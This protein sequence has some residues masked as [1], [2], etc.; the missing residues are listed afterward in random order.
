MIRVSLKGLAA[1]PIRAVLT[2]LA[3]VLGV[4]MVSGSFVVTD[5]ITKAFDT[6][7]TSSYAHT[8]AVVSKKSLVDYSNSGNG[9]VPQSLLV[10]IQRL[11]EVGAAAGSI[12]D[13]NNDT[14]NTK[15]ID[16]DGKAIDA[17]GNPTFGFGVDPSRPRFNPLHLVAGTWAHGR[18]EVVI[19]SNTA[20]KHHFAVGDFIDAAAK[21]PKE[22]FQISGI[23]KY[24]DVDTL[25]GATIAV[26]T[27]PTAQDLLELK[28]FTA[29]SVATK[30]GV[31]QER[32]VREI[33]SV[34]PGDVQVKTADEQAKADKKN[35]DTFLS[36]IRG[37]LLGFGGIA[38]FV[39]AFVIFN[40]LSITIAQRTR[41]LAT[42][43]TLGASRRQVLRSVIVE[44]LAIGVLASLIG[45]A[46]GIGLARGLTA[47]FDVMGL[48][49]P[50]SSP[51]YATRTFVV[52]LLL[53]VLVTLFAGLWPAVR[54]TRVPPIAAV[55]EGAVL[56]R[57][58]RLGPIAG[59]VLFGIATALIAYATLGG[60]LGA[61]KSLL[62]LA[63]GTLIGLLGVAGFAPALVSGLAKLVG[64][65]AR[66]LGGP[67]GQLASSNAV[68]NPA[69]TASTAAALMIGLALV[70]FVAVLGKGLH[71]SVDRALHEQVS[72]DWV[73]SSKNGWSAFTAAAGA[74]A[75]TTPGITRSTSIRSDRGRVKNANA[76]VNG[77]DPKT[78]SGL[79]NFTW[80]QGSSNGSLAR[81]G[82]TGALVKRSFANEH[83]LH[84]GDAFTL[85]TPAGKPM[86]LNVVGVFQPPRLYELLGGIVVSQQAFDRNFARPGNQ[87]TLID[88]NVSRSQLERSLASFPDT[89]IETE[90]EYVTSQSSWISTMTNLLYVLLALSVV[91]SL[92]GMVN[93]LV[94]SV[95]ERTR[96]LGMLRAVGLTRRQT[97]RMV[98]HESVITALIGA[99]L[100]LPLGILLAASVTHA[101]GKYGVA[102]SFPVVSIVAFTVTAI[103][104]GI[105]A[106][107]APARRA[108]RLD[109]LSALQYE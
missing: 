3:I 64:F 83:D 69:R 85:R 25:G 16:R 20:K 87:L 104:A 37:F 60:N 67:A 105:L 30:P 7:F 35:V 12:I 31:S 90:A 28:G 97:R 88:G 27:I 81:L 61:G 86:H 76:T 14:T 72:A 95:F 23:A 51:V 73:I 50:Q 24:G 54:A 106:A 40:T 108:S 58:K 68:R 34:V 44:S 29:I 32:L 79:Y 103:L 26:F 33:R 8:D 59:A 11:P 48:S 82:E 107:V 15:L 57:R 100:G 2:A 62:A 66:S 71:G 56:E 45:I 21:G 70:S 18:H 109:V 94:L 98:R 96:E 38:L 84:L 1:R 80:K 9:T 5:T 63:A 92:F 47:L 89:K 22:R 99:A 42:L 17:N 49:L 13:L 39:G 93:T 36:F 65:P 102:F 19:D 41:E 91:V 6:I 53:G 78:V 10:K 55:R 74:A 43:R 75:E 52:A 101:I 46:A 4:A 77:V